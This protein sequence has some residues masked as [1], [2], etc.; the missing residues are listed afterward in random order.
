[1]TLADEQHNAGKSAAS[2]SCQKLSLVRITCARDPCVHGQSYRC[3]LHDAFGAAI[4][5]TADTACVR[6]PGLR[7]CSA[8]EGACC[9]SLGPQSSRPH[10]AACQADAAARGCVCSSGSFAGCQV[11]RGR[12][13]GLT[14]WVADKWTGSLVVCHC[15]HQ[16]RGTVT[17]S[18]ML[19]SQ[20]VCAWCSG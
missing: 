5:A 3:A 8:V 12:G 14:R 9:R 2:R 10:A 20:L 4:C 16:A 18:T 17:A 13:R 11:A 6:R 19:L 15:L 7:V 1:M